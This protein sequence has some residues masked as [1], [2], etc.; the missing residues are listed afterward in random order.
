MIRS[1]T[2]PSL[3]NLIL[4]SYISTHNSA[5][6]NMRLSYI[7]MHNSALQN[8]TNT[9]QSSSLSSLHLELLIDPTYKYKGKA[10]PFSICYCCSS[11]KLH[12]KLQFEP[13]I[14]WPAIG[15]SILAHFQLLT[16]QG[17]PLHL[18]AG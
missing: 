8:K 1:F 11:W 10:L 9:C 3:E 14:F 5:L 15:L 17:N 16:V 7:S 13:F 18:L 6:Q 4:M 12:H 2:Y